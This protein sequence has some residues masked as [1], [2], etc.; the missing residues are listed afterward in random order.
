M[1]GPFWQRRTEHNWSIP[2]GE[3]L[4]DEPAL[5]AARREFT[6]ELGVPVPDVPLHDLGTV[7]Q[8]GGKQVQVWAGEGEIDLDRVVYGTFEMEWPRGSGR[9]RR[10]PELAEVAWWSLSEARPRLVAAQLPFLDR[11]TD[12]LAGIGRSQSGR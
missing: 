3:Y 10:F 4:A 2:K 1:G 7:T 9:L 11:L 5:D 8:S 6:E 12:Q